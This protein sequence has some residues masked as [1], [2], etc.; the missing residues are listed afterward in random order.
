MFVVVTSSVVARCKFKGHCYPQGD[1]AESGLRTEC[2]LSDPEGVKCGESKGAP[3][4]CSGS[5]APRSVT[6]EIICSTVHVHHKVL[7]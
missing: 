6:A 5:L 7:A 3:M 1:K 2:E 4:V